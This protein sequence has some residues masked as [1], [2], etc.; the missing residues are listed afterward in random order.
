MFQRCS[1]FSICAKV[2]HAGE[3]VGTVTIT[4]HVD[5]E[6]KFVL[7]PTG[8]SSIEI[9]GSRTNSNQISQHFQQ[10]SEF[11]FHVLSTWVDQ[12]YCFNFILYFQIM[13]SILCCIRFWSSSHRSHY[14]GWLLRNLRCQLAKWRCRIGIFW[15]I[16]IILIINQ[17]VESISK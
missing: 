7:D 1:K 2:C 11:R 16:F 14:A 3:V 17:F 10:F 5:I 9:T 8:A 15:R 12:I 4:D 6:R 13:F